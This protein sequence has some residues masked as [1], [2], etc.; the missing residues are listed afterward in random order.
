[1]HVVLRKVSWK[2]T[3]TI[4]HQLFR[5]YRDTPLSGKKKDFPGRKY[6]EMWGSSI[7]HRPKFPN[8]SD[9]IRVIRVEWT[10]HNLA[11]RRLSLYFI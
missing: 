5:H 9:L 3:G 1:M 11:A 8:T 7:L 2:T 6:G 4:A 10:D